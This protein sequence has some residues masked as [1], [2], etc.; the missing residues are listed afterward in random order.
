MQA[1]PGGP[2]DRRHLDFVYQPIRGGDGEV[3]GI[4]VEGSDVTDRVEQQRRRDLVFGLVDRFSACGSPAE[5]AFAASEMLGTALG[6]SRVGYGSIDHQADTLEVERDWTAAGVESLAG[7]TN[8]RDYGSFI[9]S[10]KRGEFISIADVRQDPRTEPAAAALEGKSARSFVNVPVLEGGFLPAVFFVNFGEVR[11]WSTQDL[12]LIRDVGQRTRVSVERLRSSQA[13]QVSERRLREANEE[14]EAKV[15]ARTGEPLAIEEQFRQSQKM[16]AIGQL[17]GG[18]AHDFNNLLASISGSLELLRKRLEQKRYHELGRYVEIGRGATQRAAALTHRL[19]A[20]SR[21]QTLDP[22][23]ADVGTIVAGMEERVRRSIG[24]TLAME[25]EVDDGLWG[26]LVDA[27]QLENAL[28]NLCINARDAMPG[29]GRLGIKCANQPVIGA[30]AA[31]WDMEPGDYVAVYVSD[32]G[33]GMPPEL[34]ARVFEPFYTTKPLGQGTGLGLSMVDGFAKQSGGA[35]RIHSEVGVGTAVCI[36]L[37][38][39]DAG[40]SE[41]GEPPAIAPPKG[42]ERADRARG[43]RRG[44]GAHARGGRAA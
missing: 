13:L 38:R 18:L 15:A 4:F 32:T 25:V 26:V 3:E 33:A 19:L 40:A 43:G 28:L 29:G 44:L 9:D 23:P 27:P 14:L 41:D 2:I 20:F 7:T 8:L 36:Y 5:V 10:L 37:P 34:V 30:T 11:Q 17:T 39:H 12:E 6:V 42:R 16:E 1:E 21:R 31:E 24:P 22:K 35:V